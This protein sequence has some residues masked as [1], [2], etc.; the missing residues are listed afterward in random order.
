V[1]VLLEALSSEIVLKKTGPKTGHYN[2]P[3]L[4]GVLLL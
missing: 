4:N 3:A 2:E 1:T